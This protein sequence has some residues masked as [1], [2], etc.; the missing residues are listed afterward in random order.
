MFKV[1]DKGTRT[2]PKEIFW[3]SNLKAFNANFNVF[4]L[5][6][7]FIYFL[8]IGKLLHF[9]IKYMYLQAIAQ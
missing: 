3:V 2:M 9:E 7:T 5:D 8:F 6:T 1:T 4:L